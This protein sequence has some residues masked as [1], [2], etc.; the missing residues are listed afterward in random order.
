MIPPR[1]ILAAV[2]FSQPS[3]TA[4]NFAAHLARQCGA[5]LHVLHAEDPLLAA[6]AKASGVELSRETRE[7]LTRFAESVARPGDSPVHYHIVI[8]AG[9]PTICHVAQR[10]Q[11]DVIVMGMHGMSGPARAMFGST[12]EGV[13]RQARAS[14][15]VVPDSWVPPRADTGDLSG[16]G[17]VVA[18]IE[19]SEPA[20]AGAAAACR[21][22]AALGTSVDLVHIVPE[23]P[24][25]DRWRGHADAAVAQR[26][27]EARRELGGVLPMLGATVPVSLRIETGAVA[28]GIANSVVPTADRQPLL[29]LGRRNRANRLGPPGATAYRV[30]TLARVPVLVYLPE[31]SE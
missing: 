23:L 9:T 20:I 17:P 25:L 1:S 14:V 5:A 27:E 22:A 29:V 21:M 7:E 8:G 16:M 12:T 28:E 24:V 30:L 3:R 26:I 13:L 6:A 2:D 18:A 15:L 11:L 4:P 10:E 19:C 31:A